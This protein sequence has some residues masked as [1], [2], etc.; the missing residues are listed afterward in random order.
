[1]VFSE[2]V[3]GERAFVGGLMGLYILYH[4]EFMDVNTLIHC[5]FILINARIAH[6]LPV[7]VSKLLD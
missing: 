5:S 1:M 4:N 7:E 6:P 2:V 3:Y